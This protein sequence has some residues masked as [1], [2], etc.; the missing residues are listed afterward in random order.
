M[1]HGPSTVCRPTETAAVGRTPE[2]P[3]LPPMGRLLDLV[4]VARATD[5]RYGAELFGC[6]LDRLLQPRPSLSPRGVAALDRL[7]TVLGVAV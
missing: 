7:T 1:G 5:D 2:V 6:M 4:I 3:P